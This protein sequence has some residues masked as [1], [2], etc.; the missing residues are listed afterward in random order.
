VNDAYLTLLAAVAEAHNLAI[1]ATATQHLQQHGRW[2]EEVWVTAPT[3]GS[4]G[5]RM[6][7]GERPVGML[8]EIYGYGEL[9]TCTLPGE[10]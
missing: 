7:T 1:E 2:P 6:G 9:N 10:H 5:G 4:P 8:L 3:A